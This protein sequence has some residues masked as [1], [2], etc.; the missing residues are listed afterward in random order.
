MGAKCSDPEYVHL[1]QKI[2]FE[3]NQPN[4]ECYENNMMGPM[5]E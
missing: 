5:N 4:V 3:L 1:L 2:A